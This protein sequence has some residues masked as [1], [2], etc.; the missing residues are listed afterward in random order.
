VVQGKRFQEIRRVTRDNGIINIIIIIICH[1][2]A[3]IYTVQRDA[4][5][6]HV[7][8]SVTRVPATKPSVEFS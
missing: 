4:F 7:S 2:S 5:R 6:D 3:I 1:V 8:P